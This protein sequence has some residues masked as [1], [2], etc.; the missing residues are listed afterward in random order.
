[1]TDLTIHHTADPNADTSIPDPH[2]DHFS[3]T[4]LGFWVYLMTDCILFATLFVTYAVLSPNTFGGPT[5]KDLFHLSTAFNETIILLVSSLTGGFAVLAAAKNKFNIMYLCLFITFVLG[6]SFL[7]LEVT[8]FTRLV[9]EG[10]SWKVSAFLSSFFV[11]VGTHGLHIT[12]G[13]L[14]LVVMV[15]QLL[16]QGLTVDTFRRLVIFSL[17]WHFLDLIWIFVFTFVYLMGV[18]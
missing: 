5:P 15:F 11:L 17:F 13:V 7:F 4:V 16:F 10:N 2:Q 1:M 9:N 12:V 14:W 3:K 6:V 18:I 8:E